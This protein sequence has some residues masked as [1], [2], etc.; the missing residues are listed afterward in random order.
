[1]TSWLPAGQ[2]LCLTQPDADML[3]ILLLSGMLTYWHVAAEFNSVSAPI[4]S[5]S[6]PRSVISIMAMRHQLMWSINDYFQ[7]AHVH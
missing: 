5:Q 3:C 4:R 7:Q 2:V 1:M 6:F